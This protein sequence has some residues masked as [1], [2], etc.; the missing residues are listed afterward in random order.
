MTSINH[1]K[2][3]NLNDW[4]T[5]CQSIRMNQVDGYCNSEFHVKLHNT[6]LPSLITNFNEPD[7]CND[8]SSYR[9]CFY[10]DRSKLL[11]I[12][13]KRQFK[14][15]NINSLIRTSGNYITKFT[16]HACLPARTT[17]SLKQKCLGNRD[18]T[19]AYE[20]NMLCLKPLTTN[21]TRVV[22][23]THGKGQD[24]LFVGDPFELISSVK[25]SNYIPKY[26]FSLTSLPDHLKIL[27]MYLLSISSALAIL[28]MVPC[29][30]LDGHQ[31]LSVL[32]LMLFP[33]K[34][35]TRSLLEPVILFFGSCL[36]GVNIIIA[37][38]SL[39]ANKDM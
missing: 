16:E 10:Y 24:I 9:F 20:K 26:I 22:R 37:L 36:L 13:K 12:P 27:S 1:C 34:P 30:F 7:C 39:V 8:T 29:F 2:I 18:C 14:L 35:T 21:T 32:L 28:N 11:S 38:Y 6:S 31:S 33:D 5:C 19:K 25:M 15:E 3:Q 17:M 4:Y 23:I